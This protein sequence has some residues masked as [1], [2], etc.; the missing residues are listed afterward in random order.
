MAEDGAE[1]DIVCTLDAEIEGLTYT[2]SWTSDLGGSV[3]GDTVDANLT[4]VNEEW[5]CTAV[6][7]DGIDTAS[8]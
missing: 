3:N 1:G 8:V 4:S 6:V 2:Y 5:T 7:G